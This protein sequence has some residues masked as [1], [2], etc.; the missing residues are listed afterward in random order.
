MPAKSCLELPQ[1]R[2]WY[3]MGLVLPRRDMV[4][5]V[6]RRSQEWLEHV[7]WKIHEQLLT[8]GVLHMDETHIQCIKKR[9]GKPAAS[10]LCGSCG[11]PRM[12]FSPR[13]RVIFLARSMRSCRSASIPKPVTL[14]TK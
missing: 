2:E 1:E 11:A 8:C 4:N 13:T 5:W 6:I 7:Y 9:T 12:R 10:P 3:R 14:F